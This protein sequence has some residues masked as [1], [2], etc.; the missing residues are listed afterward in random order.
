[1]S[2]PSDPVWPG[3]PAL[4]QAPQATVRPGP[5]LS[6]RWKDGWKEPQLRPAHMLSKREAGPRGNPLFSIL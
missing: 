1:M 3:R 4:R 6:K 5:M 2:W